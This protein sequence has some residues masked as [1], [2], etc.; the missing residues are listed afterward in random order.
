MR[1][2]DL[3]IRLARDGRVSAAQAADQLDRVV[4]DILRTIRSGKTA[5]LPG[6]GRFVPG[7]GDTITFEKSSSKAAER[8]RG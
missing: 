7:E 1:K 2:T 8:K 4:R 5:N 3:A 6:L